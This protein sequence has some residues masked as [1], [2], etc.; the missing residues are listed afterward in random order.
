MHLVDTLFEFQS[1]CRDFISWKSISGAGL[2]RTSKLFQSRC[3]DFISWKGGGALLIVPLIGC[4]SPVAGILL[5]ESSGCYRWL[6]GID[7]CFS[8]VA[9]ILLVESRLNPPILTRESLFQSRCR[10]FISWK[11]KQTIG[12]YLAEYGFSPVAGILL[13]ERYDCSPRQLE[14]IYVS[15]PLPGFY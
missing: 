9:G 10:D 5:V 3:R 11:T 4:F 13:V 8:P 6:R 14:E 1:R 15:V 7:S 2:A 12:E